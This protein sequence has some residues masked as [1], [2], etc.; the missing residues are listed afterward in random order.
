MT[1]TFLLDSWAIL[2]YLKQ[3]SP[4]DKR[5]IDLLEQAREGTTK[6]LISI[7]NLGEVFYI[8]G[9]IRGEDFAEQV[10]VSLRLL[11]IEILPVNEAAV[12]AAARWKMRYPL[13]Y[14]D[15][16]AAA[17]AEEYQVTLL[18]GDPELLALMDVLKIETLQRVP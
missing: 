3:E 5:V 16:F 10:L 9:R 6:L 8:V 13:S 15:A 11:P 1:S 18:T 7:V 4:A 12:F 14:A 17:A 2:A